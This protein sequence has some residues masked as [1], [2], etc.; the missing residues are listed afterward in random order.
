[1]VINVLGNDSDP[2]NDTLTIGDYD[3]SSTHGGTV[4]CTSTGV[5][6]YTPPA[7]FNG[8]DTFTYTASDGNGGTDIA[9]VT[10]SIIAAPP[11]SLIYFPIVLK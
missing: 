6:T 3:T 2:D 9:T 7:D 8:T 1:V 5:C 10:I 11:E 4:G